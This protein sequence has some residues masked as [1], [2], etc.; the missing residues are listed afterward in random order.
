MPPGPHAPATPSPVR[1]RL[2]AARQRLRRAVLG[3]RRLLAALCAG[4]AVVAGVRAV[5]APVPPGVDVVV[6]ARALPAG[7]VLGESDLTTATLPPD[8]VPDDVLTAG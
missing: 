2:G 4:L 8:T 6:A 7:A 1:R 5:A 3:R